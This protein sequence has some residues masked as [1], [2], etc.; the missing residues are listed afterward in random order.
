M[1]NKL[2]KLLI[3]ITILSSTVAIGWWVV[4]ELV[5]YGKIH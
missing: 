5:I 3:A 1:K 2:T 4:L